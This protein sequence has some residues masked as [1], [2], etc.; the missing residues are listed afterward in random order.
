MASSFSASSAGG[1]RFG[2]GEAVQLGQGLV[3]VVD[4]DIG[5][6]P[7]LGQ[8]GGLFAFQL[9]G[10]QRAH[11]LRIV[12]ENLRAGHVRKQVAGEGASRFLIRLQPDVLRCRMGAAHLL[13]GEAVADRPLGGAS[14]QLLEYGPLLFRV[15][16]E[17]EGH[18]R[19]HVQLLVPV[20]LQD[21]GVNGAELQ[22]LLD[23]ERRQPEAGGDLLDRVSGLVQLLEC[24][25]LVGRVHPGAYDV[26]DQ[27]DLGDLLVLVDPHAGHRV[28]AVDGDPLDGP[29]LSGNPR[30]RREPAA[31]GYHLVGIH[32]VG[33]LGQQHL[34]VLADAV[35]LDAGFQLG[36]LLGGGRRLPDVVLRRFEL[37]QRNHLDVG[38]GHGSISSS[39]R[40]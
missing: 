7:A 16:A 30:E 14:A 35:G 37:P 33:G 8:Q 10:R 17:G 15:A 23:G 36:V 20:G 11:Q 5:P 2:R 12:E 1:L 39:Q 29:A 24:D 13:A 9:P 31:A 4:Q 21:L 6:L 28:V 32:P 27:A 19:L 3:V 26:L 40:R 22:P 38:C 25:H 34:Q 18:D